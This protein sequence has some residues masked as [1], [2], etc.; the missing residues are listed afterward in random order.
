LLAVPACYIFIIFTKALLNSFL[1]KCA[2][3][4]LV[5]SLKI[6]LCVAYTF[7]FLQKNIYICSIT[8]LSFLNNAKYLLFPSLNSNYCT[9]TEFIYVLEVFWLSSSMWSWSR[10]N[11]ASNCWEPAVYG[12]QFSESGALVLFILRVA[13]Q[14]CKTCCYGLDLKSL[15]RPCVQVWVSSLRWCWQVL[16]PLGGGA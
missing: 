3:I 12:S 2:Y 10:L 13:L 15:P 5:K 7:L 16:E 1:Y 8:P 4:F 11:L 6:W 9:Y 14:I